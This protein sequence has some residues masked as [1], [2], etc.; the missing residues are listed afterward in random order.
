MTLVASTCILVGSLSGSSG[1]AS[2]VTTIELGFIG[3]STG[4]MSPYGVPALQGSDMA[5]LNLN[6]KGFKVKG[7]TYKFRLVIC[8][9]QGEDTTVASCANQ[10]IKTDHV[11]YLFGG[12]G[13]FAPIVAQI[14]NAAGVVYF[15]T[16]SAASPLV[17]KYKR[18]VLALPITSVK[19]EGMANGIKHFLPNAKTAA[20]LFP[21]NVDGQTIPPFIQ[22][23]L[24]NVGINVVTTQLYSPTATDY[25]SEMTAI[26]ALKPDVVVFGETPSEANIVI[27][28]NNQLDASPA[29]FGWAVGCQSAI[30]SSGGV[31]PNGSYIGFTESGLDVTYSNSPEAKAFRSEFDKLY[32]PP[33]SESLSSALLDYDWYG[34]L[35]AAMVKAESTAPTSVLKA[36]NKVVYNGAYGKI[37]ISNRQ[38]VFGFD[39][40]F[41]TNGSTPTA[42][43]INP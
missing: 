15:T 19:A 24:N 30:P 1:A 11:K 12:I 18:M 37:T 35:A 34:V 3:D 9:D 39:E 2:K 42:T 7:Q 21:D 29:L 33:A 10:L 20:I 26:A 40:C 27:G 25:S 14:A 32:N 43:H 13:P 22:I 31:T 41:T 17:S 38:A 8:E 28:D 23:A 5:L 16:S 4:I 36:L 6:K